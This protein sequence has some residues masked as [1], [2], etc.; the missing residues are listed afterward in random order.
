ML[1]V[2]GAQGNVKGLE[3]ARVEPVFRDISGWYGCDPLFQHIQRVDKS[4]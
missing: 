4:L 3:V 2:I 1:I